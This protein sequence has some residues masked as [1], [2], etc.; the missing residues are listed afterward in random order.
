MASVDS[1]RVAAATRSVARRRPTALFAANIAAKVTAVVLSLFPLAAPNRPQFRGKAM[2][3]RAIAYPLIPLAVPVTW[4]R[5][6]RPQ[7]Y[8]HAADLVLSLP[9]I[10]DAGANAFDVYRRV[11][12]FDLLVHTVNALFGVTVFGAALSPL[13]PNR[14]SAAALATSLGI[15]GAALWEVAEFAALKS[16]EEGL[17]L[18]YENTMLDVLTSAVGAS[19]GGIVTAAVLWPHRAE[20][21]ALF[22]WRLVERPRRRP[23]RSD[24][25]AENQVDGVA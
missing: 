1:L 22:G 11:K 20:V 19:L 6:G 2:R 21:G 3:P 9:L 16:G 23:R 15:S 4:L 17:E 8:P 10:L 12:N 18:S 7:P 14:W 5:R 24:E 25:P 13:M